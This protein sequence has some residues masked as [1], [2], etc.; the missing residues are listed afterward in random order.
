MKGSA[1]R[2]AALILGL[3]FSAVAPGSVAAITA[4]LAKQCREMMIKAYP[5][6]PAGSRTGVEQ[7]QRDYFKQCIAN[8]GSEPMSDEGRKNGQEQKQK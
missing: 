5:A 2:I 6:R 8:K 4:E 3:S 1:S 7:A